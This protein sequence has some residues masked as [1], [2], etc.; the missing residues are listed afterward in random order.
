MIPFNIES[1]SQINDRQRLPLDLGSNNQS[2]S[3]ILKMFA[4]MQSGKAFINP[5]KIFFEDIITQLNWLLENST[6]LIQK[7]NIEVTN[8]N[9]QLQNSNTLDQLTILSNNKNS[10]NDTI[11]ELNKLIS[12]INQYLPTIESMYDYTNIVSGVTDPLLSKFPEN[13]SVPNN[14][15]KSNIA[16]SVN[17]IYTK[18]TSIIG[19]LDDTYATSTPKSEL[20]LAKQNISSL[21]SKL[22]QLNHVINIY[23]NDN[24]TKSNEYQLYL[25]YQTTLQNRISYLQQNL[26]TYSS[27]PIVPFNPDSGG[28]P[29]TQKISG[30]KD[31]NNPMGNIDDTFSSIFGDAIKKV[32]FS[33]LEQLYNIKEIISGP[34]YTIKV[35]PVTDHSMTWVH[36]MPDYDTIPMG[37]FFGDRA[38]QHLGIDFLNPM[39]A[40]KPI[41]AVADGTVIV[42]ETSE[43]Y[44]NFLYIQHDNEFQSRYCQLSGFAVNVKDTVKRGQMIGYCGK[45]GS[46]VREC[47]HFE[48]RKGYGPTNDDS[49]AIEPQSVIPNLVRPQE[50]NIDKS[51]SN[52]ISNSLT[53][54]SLLS[55]LSILHNY[56]KQNELDMFAEQLNDNKIFALASLPTTPQNSYLLN[57]IGSN[58]LIK[59]LKHTITK[60]NLFNMGNQITF[61]QNISKNFKWGDIIGTGMQ[62]LDEALTPSEEI[63]TNMNKVVNEILEPLLTYPGYTD[64]NQKYIGLSGSKDNLTILRSWQSEDYYNYLHMLGVKNEMENDHIKGL[65]IDVQI[66]SSDMDHFASWCKKYLPVRKVVLYNWKVYSRGDKYTSVHL[67]HTNTDLTTTEVYTVKIAS[68]KGTFGT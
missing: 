10:Y 57:K 25:T 34:L 43:T 44:G 14:K 66:L 47:L 24:L 8:I 45:T 65:A 53:I 38:G 35:L 1:F 40:S 4:L 52:I 68:G 36:P 54:R 18:L 48:L 9:D 49:V 22:N 17:N 19:D 30:S 58:D 27:T 11:F 16:T 56:T 39:S 2:S 61:D 32:L 31:T 63:Y 62:K 23:Q 20:Q 29:I 21:T 42:K 15:Y 5:L 55:E 50:R 41:Y 67:S 64:G 28:D 59:S 37:G 6:N 33:L 51:F 12:Y 7:Y 26:K 60:P 3:D 46:A 13:Q